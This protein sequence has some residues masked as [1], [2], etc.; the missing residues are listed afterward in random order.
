MSKARNLATLLSSDGSVKTTK[1]TDS[2]GGEATFVASGT[3]PNGTAVVLKS[4]GTI[5]T[6]AASGSSDIAR[7][8]AA[9]EYQI[10]STNSQGLELRI[11]PAGLNKI[12][13]TYQ[14]P[15]SSA[16]GRAVVGTISGTVITWGTSV[17]FASS[18]IGMTLL[19]GD[20]SVEGSFL[21][22]YSASSPTVYA[23]AK[24]LTVTGTSI[25]VG[26]GVAFNSATTYTFVRNQL[27]VDPNTA[28]RF[29]VGFRDYGGSGN[30][31]AQIMQVSGSSITMGSPATMNPGGNIGCIEFN[32]HVAGQFMSASKNS[33]GHTY[34]K[35]GSVSGNSITFGSTLLLTPNSADYI[36]IKFDPHAANAGRFVMAYKDQ[37]NSSYGTGR[38]GQI[39]GSSYTIGTPVVYLSGSNHEASIVFNHLTANSLLI[40]TGNWPNDDKLIPASLNGTVISYGTTIDAN[41]NG[42]SNNVAH[43]PQLNN[44]ATY[45][46][47]YSS[48][49]GGSVGK[50]GVGSFAYDTSASN[51]TASNFLGVTTAAYTDG[52]TATIT[53][54]GGTSKNQSGL[55]PSATYYV[56]GDATLGTSAVATA[57]E[58]GKALSATSILL[59]GI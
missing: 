41:D 24:V 13:V 29:M 34:L 54:Q 21:V 23:M 25:S 53:L 20:P 27:T 22:C 39:T 57:V 1:Y 17:E 19:R 30:N 52:Q 32:P 15:A 7:H 44:L 33:S 11:A 47:A 31:E 40:R 26:T 3:L 37:N 42:S 49:S 8:N 56:Q 43:H 46:Y 10:P 5:E 48:N 16:T 2:V 50:V 38:V 59:K 18:Q 9:T 28:G 35:I 58:V 6:V 36:D 12:I 51:I 14:T 55:T 4:D 45:V